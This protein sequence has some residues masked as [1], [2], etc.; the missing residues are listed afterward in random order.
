MADPVSK[1]SPSVSGISHADSAVNGACRS[2][3][4]TRSVDP[5]PGAGRTPR[6]TASPWTGAW[7]KSSSCQVTLDWTQASSEGGGV[8]RSSSSGR[9]APRWFS[10]WGHPGTAS[11]LVTRLC[12]A[13]TRASEWP[14]GR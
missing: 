9:P 12:S 13:V 10:S 11:V 5:P 1:W 4:T 2:P 3:V 14:P 7:T 8:I 6:T